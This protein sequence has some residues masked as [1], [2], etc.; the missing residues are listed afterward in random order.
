MVI[1]D[2]RIEERR[3]KVTELGAH[4]HVRRAR[5]KGIPAEAEALPDLSLG[6]QENICATVT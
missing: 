3:A 6:A 2:C 1:F 5:R 4:G